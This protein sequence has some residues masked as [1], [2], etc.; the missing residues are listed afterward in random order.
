MPVVWPA[1]LR[2]RSLRRRAC[3]LFFIAQLADEIASEAQR[4]LFGTLVYLRGLA[5]AH[6]FAV[7]QEER[8][9]FADDDG[10]RI[11]DRAFDRDARDRNES[12]Q[13]ARQGAPPETA[14]DHRQQLPNTL[15]VR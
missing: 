6:V 12:D 11:S 15:Y 7:F 13:F 9:T 4:V 5:L 8:D 3:R 1:R 10:S 14:A 2:R